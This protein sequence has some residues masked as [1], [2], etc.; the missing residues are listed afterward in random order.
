[1]SRGSMLDDTSGLGRGSGCDV[2]QCPSGL[3]LQFA[4]VLQIGGIVAQKCDQL[5][6]DVSLNQRV[7][8]RITFPEK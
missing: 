6:H 2:C 7:D 4:V 8:G 5:G 1:M 3:E